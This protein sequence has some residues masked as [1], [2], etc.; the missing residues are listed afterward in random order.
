MSDLATKP[1]EQVLVDL[2]FHALRVRDPALNAHAAHLLPQLGDE[3]VR[4]MVREA[5]FRKNGLPYR[6]RLLG[7]I[8]RVGS[9]PTAADWLTLNT[10]AADKN[11]QIR[12]AAGRC[13][14]CCPAAGP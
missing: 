2:M 8:E 11:P 9:V 5:A 3:S 4:R 1:R 12:H 7:V 6:L 14:T 10:L 13:L